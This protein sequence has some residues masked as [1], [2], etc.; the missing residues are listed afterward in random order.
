MRTFARRAGRWWH[1]ALWVLLIAIWGATGPA[2][3]FSD[4]WQ[5]LVNT[6]T[7]V[8]ELF[9]GLAILV[10]GEATL[11]AQERMLHHISE[12]EDRLELREEEIERIARAVARR[13]GADD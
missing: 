7:T 9:L 5:L 10:D 12:Q 13:I 8:Y 4:T 11:E 2:M 3:H 6:P 1:F